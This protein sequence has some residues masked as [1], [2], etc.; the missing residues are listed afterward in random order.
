MNSAYVRDQRRREW[1]R[2]WLACSVAFC[3][4]VIWLSLGVL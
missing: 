1:N 3:F 4:G 2:R